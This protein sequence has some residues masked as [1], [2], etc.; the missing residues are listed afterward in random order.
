[1][2]YFPSI[3]RRTSQQ[4]LWRDYASLLS[5]NSL[6]DGHKGLG[7]TVRLHVFDPFTN[8]EQK[9]TASVD[10]RRGVHMCDNVA[11]LSD[12]VRK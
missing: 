5:A 9:R 6:H 1:M 2:I 3:M 11:L 8:G 7:W 12:I 10:Y 4:Q